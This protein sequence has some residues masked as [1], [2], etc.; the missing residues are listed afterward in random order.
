MAHKHNFAFV[1]LLLA[2]S[3]LAQ[4]VNP[5]TVTVNDQA[6]DPQVNN[7]QTLPRQVVL[8]RCAYGQADESCPGAAVPPTAS[9]AGSTTLLAKMPRQMGP[10]GPLGP[11]MRGSGYPGT[12]GAQFSPGHALIGAAIGFGFGAAVAAKD[13]GVRGSIAV[14]TLFGLL[15]AA[16]GSTIPAFPSHYRYRRGWDDDEEAS[17]TQPKHVKP[18]SRPDTTGQIVA[19]PDP[20]KSTIRE[21]N[22]QQAAA[23]TTQNNAFSSR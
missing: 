2:T 10:M 9:N 12:W 7:D 4:T 17:Q 8:A 6:S 14:G 15:G 23:E 11:P 20:P 19:R 22:P 21:D 18:G 5:K 3:A 1:L 16:V 13:G